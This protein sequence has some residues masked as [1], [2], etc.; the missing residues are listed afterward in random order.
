MPQLDATMPQPGA[1]KQEQD[2]VPEWVVFYTS[3]VSADAH[4]EAAIYRLD[5]GLCE[6]ASSS[7]PS[8]VAYDLDLPTD[9]LV[10]ECKAVVE[11]QDLVSSSD[12]TEVIIWD[13]CEGERVKLRGYRWEPVGKGYPLVAHFDGDRV[14]MALDRVAVYD[15]LSCAADLFCRLTYDLSQRIPPFNR[16]SAALLSACV[17]FPDDE[18]PNVLTSTHPEEVV[19]ALY[20]QYHL[21]TAMAKQYFAP[22]A[23]ELMGECRSGQCGPPEMPGATVEVCVEEMNILELREALCPTSQDCPAQAFIE[24]KL[25]FQYEDGLLHPASPMTL[26][27]QLQWIDDGWRLM[28][29]VP[30]EN[31]APP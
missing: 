14:E 7:L 3:S 2:V 26:T 31:G 23:W 24:T 16:S 10:Y 15:R 17:V 13:E 18:P 25:A 27:W 1:T 12:G 9:E 4:V 19:L 22:G 21:G 28:M 30:V 20:T 11:K 29:A 8:F 5:V 6:N